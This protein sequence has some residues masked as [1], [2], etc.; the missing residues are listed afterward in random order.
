[1]TATCNAP[2]CAPAT[3]SEAVPTLK[4][5]YAVTSDE[6]SYVVRVELPGVVKEDVS[7]D[8][9][10]EVL[11]IKANR[12]SAVPENWKPLHRELNDLGFALRLKLN[13]RVDEEKLTAQL[14]DGV[15]TLTL[16]IREAAKPRRIEVN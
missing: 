12:K 10:K 6:H 5:R 11:S 3:K 15:L 4:P 7:L 14:V 13:A 2:A 8:F 9:D 16:P 1:M